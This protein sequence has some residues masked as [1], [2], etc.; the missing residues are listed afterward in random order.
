MLGVCNEKIGC[1][2]ISPVTYCHVSAVFWVPATLLARHLWLPWMWMVV[3]EEFWGWWLQQCGCIKVLRTLWVAEEC[4]LHIHT[5]AWLENDFFY[6]QLYVKRTLRDKMGTR[7][8]AEHQ[9]SG[10]PPEVCGCWDLMDF[11]FSSLNRDGSNSEIWCLV[12][13]RLWIFGVLKLFVQEVMWSSC[14]T[15]KFQL[16]LFIS[17]MA[18]PNWVQSGHL[19]A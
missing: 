4:T 8:Y 2:S 11:G 1:C 5:M 13:P 3:L 10:P 18:K 7:E 9:G 6:L 12:Q 14:H 17:T 19:H 16:L 15:V